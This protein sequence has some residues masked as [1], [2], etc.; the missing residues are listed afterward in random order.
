MKRR[1]ADV[2]GPSYDPADANETAP[3]APRRAFLT[4]SLRKP[5]RARPMV[6]VEQEDAMVRIGSLGLAVALSVGAALAAPGARAEDGDRCRAQ[7]L[8][9]I[10]EYAQGE[11]RC[12]AKPGG[13]DG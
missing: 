2:T 8:A 4:L 9:A 10:A 13:K 1:M 11:V 3:R 6:F 12:T 5:A 7:K